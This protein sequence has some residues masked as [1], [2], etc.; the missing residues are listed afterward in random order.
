MKKLLANRFSK[1]VLA[2]TAFAVAYLLTLSFSDTNTSSGVGEFEKTLHR[3]EQ[4]LN[5]ELD[6]LIKNASGKSF[7]DIFQNRPERYNSLFHDDGLVLLIYE[8]D[9]LKFWSDN[10]VSVENYMEEVCLDDRMVKLKNGWFEVLRK[11]DA[12]GRTYIGMLLIKNEYSYQNQYLV[13]TFEKEFQVPPETEI[14]IGK[15]NS[16]NSVHASDGKYLFSLVF[17]SSG[18]V[19]TPGWQTWLNLIFNLSGFLL[20]LLFIRSESE[21]LK[22]SLGRTGALLLFVG[23]VVLLRFLTLKIHFPETFYDL[24]VFGPKYYGDADSFWISN[25][26]DFLINSLLLLYLAFHITHYLKETK[27]NPDSNRKKISTWKKVGLGLLFLLVPSF[28]AFVLNGMIIG[29]VQNSNISFDVN[30]IFDLSVYS[31]A[32]LLLIA[33][34]LATFFLIADRCARMLQ[35]LVKSPAL[36]W[37]I[38]AGALLIHTGILHIFGYV[39]LIAVMWPF[40]IILLLMVW[41]RDTNDQTYSFSLIVFLVFVFSFYGTHMLI[42]QGQHKE[43]D[44]RVLF[45]E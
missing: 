26:G 5:T 6:T 15:Q 33:I 16:A 22:N 23:S 20:T 28:G 38:F 40:A 2:L 37:N 43:H 8:S 32:G 44:S 41:R 39:D 9:T 4:A 17:K 25:L 12:S 18:P 24:P 31:Y 35:L 45:A 42:H 34:L 13:N 1:I 11:T 3:K 7:A 29:L 14:A 27:I 10:S 21:A 30:N 19:E 36:R